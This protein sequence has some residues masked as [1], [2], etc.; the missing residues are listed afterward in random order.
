[1][2]DYRRFDGKVAVATHGKGIYT[3][4]IPNVAPYGAGLSSDDFQILSVNP[5]PF[6]D[7]VSVRISAYESIYYY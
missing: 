4:E 2:I 5:N 7:F 6:S 1:M 3:S